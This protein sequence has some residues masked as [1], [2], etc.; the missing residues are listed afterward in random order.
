MVKRIQPIEIGTAINPMEVVAKSCKTSMRY[1]QRTKNAVTMTCPASFCLP[2]IVNLSS[3]KP[4]QNDAQRTTASPMTGTGFAR[5]AFRKWAVECDGADAVR[6]NAMKTAKHL[7]SQCHLIVTAGTIGAIHH[8][9]SNSPP[10]VTGLW[11]TDQ[12]KGPT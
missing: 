12:K 10:S 5:T 8:T 3:S 2:R 7:Q 1:P 4:Q 6:N 9:K 11:T